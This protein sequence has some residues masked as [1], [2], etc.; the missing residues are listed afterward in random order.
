MVLAPKSEST[1]LPPVPSGVE[2]LPFGVGAAMLA[3]IVF[4]LL[5]LATRTTVR[6]DIT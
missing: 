6:A 4:A 2:P 5:T 3:A 1:A